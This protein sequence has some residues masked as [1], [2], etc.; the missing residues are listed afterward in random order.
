MRTFDNPNGLFEGKKKTSGAT[1]LTG[2]TIALYDLIKNSG[3]RH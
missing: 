1:T 2:L 3:K